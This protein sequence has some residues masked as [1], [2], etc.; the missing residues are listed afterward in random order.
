M[1]LSGPERRILGC[2]VEK[3]R[4]T[5]QNYP[6]TLNALRLACNQ[7]TNRD[8]VTDYDETTLE[9]ALSSLRQQNLTRIVYSTS[10]RA[11]KYRHILD[12]AWKLDRDE[13]AVLAVLLLRG[14]QTVGEI[15]GRTERLTDFADLAAVQATLDRLAARPDGAFVVR[16]ERRPG[17]KDAR[18]AHLLGGSEAEDAYDPPADHAGDARGWD[19]ERPTPRAPAPAAA[20]APGPNGVDELTAEVTDL[21][22][23]LERVEGELVELRDAFEAFRAQF[24]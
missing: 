2:L 24:G 17:Q 9:E 14:P 20:A 7:S 4:A 12:E 6:L 23:Q 16:H 10:N 22:S 18:W 15:K 3:E 13:L 8:P 1:E 5:P 21:R 19:D 11:A